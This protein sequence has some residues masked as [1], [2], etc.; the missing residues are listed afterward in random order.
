MLQFSQFAY[1]R[2]DFHDVA[3][4]YR[5]LIE[6]FSKANTFAQAN[7]YLI[8]LDFLDRLFM[9]YSCISEAGNTA[10]SYDEFY[11]KEE[12][13]FGKV[14]PEA[15]HL[16]KLRDQALL[17]SPFLE[18]FSVLFGKE[19]ILRAKLAN[20]TI[21]EQALPLMQKENELSQEYSNIVSRLTVPDGNDCLSIPE[22]IRNGD[23]PE[24]E[25]R[26]KYYELIEHA[27]KQ[28]GNQFDTL[29]DEMLKIRN[30]IA[31]ST[32]FVNYTDYCL[33]K[34]GRTDYGRKELNEFT[35][36]VEKV[37]VPFVNSL[38]SDQAKRMNLP[39]LLSF[40]ERYDPDNKHVSVKEDYLKAFSKIFSQLSCETS[41]FFNELLSRKS[42][43]LDLR[44]GK[45]QGGY[46]NYL[47]LFGMP[48]IF[49]TYNATS[50]AVRTFAHECGHGLNSFLHRGEPL[51]HAWESSS[52]VSEVHSMSMEFFIW[53]YL[54]HIIER[55][56]IES[57]ISDHLKQAI[58]FIPYGVAINEFQTIVYDDPSLNIEDRLEVW[59]T[60]EQRFLP[61]RH[62]G[63]HTFSAE[64]RTWQRQIHVMKW[65]F[66]YIDYALAQTVALQ[67]C[68]AYQNDH[69]KTFASYIEFINAS[70]KLPFTELVTESGL[71]SPFER[72]TIDSIVAFAAETFKSLR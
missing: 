60:L 61:W 1:T 57:Y 31:H 23:S 46:S 4:R 72:T 27:Y 14:K 49:Q 21:S 16:N 65:P 69:E 8:E 20:M 62:H 40:D 37:L 43:D 63:E 13:F 5:Q 18:Q 9:Q 50:G 3:S 66:Y 19:P 32:G 54:E 44:Q 12:Q 39:F 52:D 71:H 28:A 41:V 59:K 15:S 51:V 25:V 35:D 42:Y 48:Y 10:N 11:Q 6:K 7:Y 30:E 58:S 64:G 56:D 34:H 38:Y 47:P 36:S 26:L 2:L 68:Q 70:G 55:N 33:A 29:F 24:R 22:A 17:G 53:D 45:V 67:F